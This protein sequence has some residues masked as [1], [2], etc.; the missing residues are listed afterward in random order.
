MLLSHAGANVT[1]L[2]RQNQVGG[3]TSTHAAHGYTFDLGP[4]FFLY[5]EILRGIYEQCGLDFE[6]EIEMQRLDPHYQL[7]FEDNDSLLASPSIEWMDS[8]AARL[9]PQDAGGFSR[10]LAQNRRK[11]ASFAPVLRKPF[12][13]ARDLFDP[14]LL[15]LLPFFRPG[16][17]V[18]Q[19]L[20]SFFKDPRLR[21]ACGFQSKYL[22]MSPK[23]CPSIFTILS[24]LEYEYGIFHPKGGC[25]AVS[26][27]MADA[28]RRL[29]ADIRLNEPVE[30]L[31]F[32]G[33]RPTSVSTPKGDYRCDALVINADFSHAMQ[34]LVPDALRRKW[35]DA[36]IAKKRY[37][38]STFMLYLGVKKTFPDLQHHTVFLS[39]TYEQNLQDIERDHCLC[40]NPALYVCN[41]VRTDPEMAPPGKSALYVLVPVTH[42]HDNVDWAQEGRRYRDLALRQMKK[43]G[44][45]I[46]ESDIEYERALSPTQWENDY[47]VHKGAVFN[48]AHTLDQMLFLRPQ[49]RF[50][51]LEGVYLVGGGTHPGSGL[52]VIYESANITSRLVLRDLGLST[53][54]AAK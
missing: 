17:S 37:S 47:A 5:P 15:Q 16:R 25:G 31:S 38:C 54:L 9:S 32:D 8:E 28:A 52:P 12:L 10:F 2:E 33:R 35:S 23:S 45:D 6:S 20:K 26:R 14:K 43:I 1:V 3:R 44:I 41:P 18:D 46:A 21:L 39:K 24:Y 51:D 42:R 11:F 27:A 7:H 48:L 4:T 53:A 49:N 34:R 29:G 40:E 30:A 36:K 19:D 13:S 50:A 22:G